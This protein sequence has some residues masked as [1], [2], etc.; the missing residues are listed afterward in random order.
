[1]KWLTRLTTLWLVVI[2]GS[3]LA[4]EPSVADLV[5][6]LGPATSS[7]APKVVDVYRELLVTDPADVDPEARSTCVRY[8]P[9]A[10]R[11]VEEGEG[12]SC[13]TRA[14]AHEALAMCRWLQGD[15]EAAAEEVAA[16]AVI[17][18]PG[19]EESGLDRGLS[20]AERWLWAAP[21]EAHV[22][23]QRGERGEA[24]RERL[25]RVRERR[26]AVEAAFGVTPLRP[27]VLVVSVGSGTAAARAGVREGDVLVGVQART[28]GG[29]EALEAALESRDS[30]SFEYLRDGRRLESTW[31][32]GA[33]GLGVVPVPERLSGR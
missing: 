7:G 24:R 18:C 33:D 6:R 16:L 15:D 8:L 28:V 13:E 2:T 21:V 26:R 25:E 32:G 1:M 17:R 20:L 30:T 31:R 5:R 10:V 23:R 12:A 14:A 11:R 4:A 29:R 22:A 3:V 9:A 27:G 19:S